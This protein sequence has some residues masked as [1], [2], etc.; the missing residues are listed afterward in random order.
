MVAGGGVVGGIDVEIVG[1]ETVV[2][3]ETAVEVDGRG[4][5]VNADGALLWL[6]AHTAPALPSRTRSKAARAIAIRIGRR[7]SERCVEAG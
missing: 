3:V 6:L 4:E 1:A 2:E 7:R 5:I